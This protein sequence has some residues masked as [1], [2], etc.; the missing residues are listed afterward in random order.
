MVNGIELCDIPRVHRT[1]RHAKE[2]ESKKC[3]AMAPK[4][5]LYSLLTSLA[6]TLEYVCKL[7]SRSLPILCDPGALCA[8]VQLRNWKIKNF[9]QKYLNLNS[10]GC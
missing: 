2:S 8:I 1:G 9:Q 4:N 6:L 10:S 7:I 3:A 5:W